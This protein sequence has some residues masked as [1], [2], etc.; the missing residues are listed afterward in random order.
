MMKYIGEV[1]G[2]RYTLFFF[3]WLLDHPV[4][5]LTDVQIHSKM[6]LTSRRVFSP[7]PTLMTPKSAQRLVSRQIQAQY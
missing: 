5:S 1:Y 2:Y 4:P 3:F 6:Q 7:A